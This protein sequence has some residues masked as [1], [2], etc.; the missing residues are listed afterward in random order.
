LD[1][2]IYLGLALVISDVRLKNMAYKMP[3]CV[4]DKFVIVL[5]GDQTDKCDVATGR[6]GILSELKLIRVNRRSAR[7]FE[8][9]ACA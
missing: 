9:I 3:L 7:D 4:S 6:N 2:L 1:L 8:E 5:Q